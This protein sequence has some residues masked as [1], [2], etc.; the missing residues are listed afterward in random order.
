MQKG[1]LKLRSS[2]HRELITLT[3]QFIRE[4]LFLP[5]IGSL[6][7]DRPCH[8][9]RLEIPA[10]GSAPPFAVAMPHLNESNP[11]NSPSG[12]LT[13]KQQLRRSLLQQR[14]ALPTSTWQTLSQQL[15]QQVQALAQFQAA[16]TVLAYFSTR[17]EPDL[18]QLIQT[19]P[20][21]RWGFPHCEGQTL[22][23]RR[24]QWGDDLLSGRYGIS[25]P[26]ATAEPVIPT[27][28]DLMLVP[29]VGCD[30]TG[31]RLGYGGGFYDRCLANPELSQLFTLG[32]VFDFALLDVLSTD[33]WDQPLH[34][35]CTEKRS[36]LLPGN[37]LG[38]HAEAEESLGSPGDAL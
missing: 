26:P 3:S 17:Q 19:H 31:N 11:M 9:I 36:L 12:P 15:C 5:M 7:A 35:I 28:A 22:Q 32:L 29:A 14:Q 10:V 25:E 2:A 27:S 6:P 37:P 34:G 20:S 30:Q 23:W 8:C 33:P 13:D 38:R 16:H 1:P 4:L 21:K 18:S 24:W